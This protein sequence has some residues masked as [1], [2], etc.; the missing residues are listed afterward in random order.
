M[1][2]IPNRL[3]NN[4]HVS[5]KDGFLRGSALRSPIDLA[6]SFAS[7]QL[8]DELAFNVGMDPVEFRRVNISNPRWLGVLDAV[9]RA[10]K[11]VPR[12]QARRTRNSGPILKG[13]GVALG[14][15]F[16]SHGAAVADV[17]VNRD[18]GE[19]RVTHLYGV[20][21]A[22]LV[23]NP[24]LVESQIMGMLMQAT[25]RVLKEEVTFTHERVTSLDWS[26]YPVL[27][28]DEHPNITAIVLQR[29]EEKSTGAGE[30]TMGAAAGA[31]ANAVFD[32][33]G[34]RF[35]QFPL[36]PERVKAALSA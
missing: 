34:V 33:T 5:A 9:T 20:L 30:E 36:R 1:Y 23:I 8:I 27:R 7:E 2:D 4:H 24:G 35:R 15:H 31:I 28:F 21:D 10:S 26:S 25:S 13:R 32:A 29:P 3:I 19:V 22:G 12:T 6:I 14:T 16:V 18:T 11:W 17:E